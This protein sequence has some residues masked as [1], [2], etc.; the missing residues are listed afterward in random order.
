MYNLY[1][2]CISIFNKFCIQIMKDSFFSLE[3]RNQAQV[4]QIPNS[5]QF[6]RDSNFVLTFPDEHKMKLVTWSFF[7][8]GCCYR[9]ADSDL[10]CS[11]EPCNRSFEKSSRCSV[12][13]HR[14]SITVQTKRR[15]LKGGVNS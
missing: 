14:R 1:V 6:Y 8:C 5:D 11:C 15:Q 4:G 10:C 12:K 13:H 3:K 7:H 2:T 9:H